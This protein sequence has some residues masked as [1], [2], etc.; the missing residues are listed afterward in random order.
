M[1]S[2]LNQPAARLDEA[3]QRLA[4]VPGVEIMQVSAYYATPP[5]GVAEQPWFVNA[6]AQLRTRLSPQALLKTMLEIEETMG[7]VRTIHWGPRLID[8]DLLLYNELILET[9]TLTIPHPE[10]HRRGFV[11]VPL[12]EIAPDA[13]HP[14][15]QQ[16]VAQLLAQLDPTDRIARRL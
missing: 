3:R 9:A 10:M 8:L 5:L 15:L 16:T 4:A 6:A 11:L 13:W 2:N 7:R 14:R 12:A 1:G